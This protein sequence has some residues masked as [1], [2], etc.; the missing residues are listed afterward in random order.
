MKKILTLGLI[1]V[2]T[3]VFAQTTTQVVDKTLDKVGNSANNI[4]NKASDAVSTVYGDG[5]SVVQQVYSDAKSVAPKLE[6]AIKELAHGLKVGA[7]QVWD[8]I[9]KQQLVWSW[10]ILMVLIL[11]CI[12]WCHF[13]YRM[14]IGNS[15]NNWDNN[16]HVWGAFITCCVAITGTIL[17]GIHFSDMMTGFINPEYSAMK[18]IAE[19]ASQIK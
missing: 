19:I 3:L 6:E 13:W 9:V 11:T 1:A 12:S 2:S 15:N 14:K 4:A 10:C 16:G 7:G 17:T 18:T 5:K 8:I